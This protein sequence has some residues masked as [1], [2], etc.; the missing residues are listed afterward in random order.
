MNAWKNLAPN[1]CRQRVVIELLVWDHPDKEFLENY[2]MK[3]SIE[4]DMTPVDWPY[5]YP[6]WELWYWWWI[7]RTTSGAHIYSYPPSSNWTNY[8]LVTID[9][10]TCKPFSLNKAVEF[11][12]EYYDIIDISFKE[13]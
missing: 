9:A 7:H 13:I 3:L 5:I 8:Y 10:Y 4:V 6:C 11:T 2:L 1:H 12:K